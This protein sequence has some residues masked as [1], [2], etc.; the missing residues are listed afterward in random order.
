MDQ[1]K[2]PPVGIRFTELGDG[3]ALK[4][5]LEEKGVLLGQVAQSAGL[6]L[7]GFCITS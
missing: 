5:W 6:F 4:E 1:Q 3:P 2:K 7:D